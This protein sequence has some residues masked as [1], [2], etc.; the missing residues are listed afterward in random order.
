MKPHGNQRHD[1]QTVIDLFL[2]LRNQRQV[3]DHLGIGQTSV[4]SILRRHG[5]AVG[6]GHTRIHQLPLDEIAARY[7]AG[8]S[9]IQLGQ[10]Y[11]VDSEV[12]RRQLE[13]EGVP[14]RALRESRARGPKNAQWKGGISNVHWY[15]R[16]SYEAAAICL[17]HPLHPD[18]VIHHIDENPRNNH[19]DNL[20]LFQGQG[21]HLRLHQQ[22]GALRRKGQPVDATRLALENGG[23]RLPRPPAPIVF[24]PDIDPRAL[25]E[26]L[27]SPGPDPAAS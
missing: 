18:W 3:A 4:S 12:I 8:E 23:L 27:A 26:R 11:G 16:E 22:L 24:G 13:V 15:R 7:R 9:T 14:R 6:K 10:A 20:V 25:Y 5:I 19:P 17:G 2:R 1:P 21:P